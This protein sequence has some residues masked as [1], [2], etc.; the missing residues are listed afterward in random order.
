MTTQEIHAR[1][2]MQEVLDAFPGAQRALMR[3][4]HIGGCSHCG[5]DLS[6]HLGDVLAKHSVL[7]VAEV[8]EYIKTSH[9]QEQ[10]LQLSPQELA[11]VLEGETVPRLIDVRSSEEQAIVKL[12]SGLPLTQAL[13]QEMTRDWPKDTPIVFYCHHG[14][15][16]L[17]AAS[18]Y[19]GHGFTNA[20]S[21]RG[22]IDAWAQEVD[23]SLSRY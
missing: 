11:Q 22:G 6:D 8:L 3:Q 18:Y 17:E 19:I 7:N 12:E 20:R 10:Q 5:F 1:S 14:I 23:T 16:S 9:E 2:S 13:T 15:R 4:Y 21:L